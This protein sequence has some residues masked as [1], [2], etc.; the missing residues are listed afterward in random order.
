MKKETNIKT[1]E[2]VWESLH[3]DNIHWYVWNDGQNM[4]LAPNYFRDENGNREGAPEFDDPKWKNDF[5]MHITDQL[6][7]QIDMLSGQGIDGTEFLIHTLLTI[8]HEPSFHQKS[9][10]LIFVSLSPHSY[11]L[12]TDTAIKQYEVD[13][14]EFNWDSVMKLAEAI[15]D[16]EFG[17]LSSLPNIGQ[18]PTTL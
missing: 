16:I 9:L 13:T 17:Q 15:S 3:A 7:G 8:S 11:L 6:A 2:Q 12:D 5:T 10:D 18:R 1:V 14:K 4:M